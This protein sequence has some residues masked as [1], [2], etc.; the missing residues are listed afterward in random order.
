MASRSF[1][2][3]PL[4]FTLACTSINEAGDD[5]EG[6]DGGDGGVASGE[7]G[8]G[9]GAQGEGGGA[10]CTAPAQPE[11]FELGTGETYFTRANPGTTLPMIQGPKAA[12]TC[13]W[14]SA[15]ATAS[16]ASTC[17]GACAIPRRARRCPTRTIA[18][19]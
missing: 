17:A 6:G 3:L 8:Q 18:K 16:P 9:E 7:G 5:G 13:G 15:A 10:A 4:L 11:P 14:R 1:L 19:A 12:I 2:M